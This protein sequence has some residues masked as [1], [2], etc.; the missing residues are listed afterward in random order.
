MLGVIQRSNQ[1][2]KDTVIPVDCP[3]SVSVAQV[4]GP[5]ESSVFWPNHKPLTWRAVTSILA[6]RDLLS[7]LRGV[8]ALC[9]LS[10]IHQ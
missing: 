10:V 5:V 4:Q 9:H 1:Q 7:T 2:S 3:I 8:A 6:V